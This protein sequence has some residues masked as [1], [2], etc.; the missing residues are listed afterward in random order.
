MLNNLNIGSGV[1]FTSDLTIGGGVPIWLNPKDL[2]RVT[3]GFNI[4][5]VPA[6]RCLIPGGTPITY[7]EATRLANICFRFELYADAAHDDTVYQIVKDNTKYGTLAKVGMNIMAMPATL[8]TDGAAYAITE[9]DTSNADYDTITLGTTI[10][11]GY[12]AGDVL[13]EADS[14]HAST[15]VL[16]YTAKALTGRDLLVEDDNLTYSAT[17]VYFGA[18][19]NRRIRKIAAIERAALPQ[20]KFSESK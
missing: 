15:A 19:Y 5:N 16:L 2:Q 3:G 18:I 9:I 8:A 1:G 4:T 17:G 20:I 10:G 12:S 6:A 13:A 7:D 11:V 14:A